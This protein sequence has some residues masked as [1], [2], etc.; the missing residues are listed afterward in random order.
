[1]RAMQGPW[2]WLVVGAIVVA[3]LV[4]VVEAGLALRADWHPVGDDALIGLRARDVFTHPTLIGQ[5]DSAD[6]LG[7]R[8]ESAHPGPIEAFVLAPVVAVLGPRAGL[9][10]GVAIING[11]ALAG[12]LLL[13]FRR[14][15]PLLLALTSVALAVLVHGL[16]PSLFHD[17]INS[18]V[19]TFVLVPLMLGAWSLWEGDLA[20][21]PA[22]ALLSAFSIQPHLANAL[23]GIAATVFGI[24]AVIRV[25]RRRSRSDDRRWL[26]VGGAVTVIAWLPPLLWELVGS[27]SN[28]AAQWDSLQESGK[29]MGLGF[30]LGRASLAVAPWPVPFVGRA[31]VVSIPYGFVSTPLSILGMTLLGAAGALAIWCRMTRRRGPASL[32]VLLLA[33]IGFCAVVSQALPIASAVRPEHAR[34]VWVLGA[35]FWLAMAWT[36]WS[37]IPDA[38]RRPFSR[39]FAAGLL[40]VAVVLVAVSFDRPRLAANSGAWAM[41]RVDGFTRAVQREV[42]KGSYL[43]KPMGNA[44]LLTVAPAVVLQLDDAGYRT[45]VEEGPFNRGY[46]RHHFHRDEPLSGVLVIKAAEQQDPPPGGRLLVRQEA[47]PG[48]IGDASLTLEAY[49][50][51][52]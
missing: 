16:D 31:T 48:T 14:G 45:F 22:F 27:S 47:A 10:L 9:A 1:V 21:L 42:P 36:G 40:A 34:W 13:G 29:G 37:S 3:G 4:P 43:V 38:T 12:A 15:G 41:P 8:R 6:A 44:A 28:V 19:A 26:V 20:V 7:A 50:V 23:V 17:P 18:D 35:L 39:P 32:L 30:S 51:P 52:A 11:L 25:I 49:L 2:R 33:T 46:D 5:P 24:A